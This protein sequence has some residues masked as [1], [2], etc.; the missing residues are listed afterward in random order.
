[1]YQLLHLRCRG[2][3]A[4][5]FP[6]RL[7]RRTLRPEAQRCRSLL[8]V[9]LAVVLSRRPWPLPVAALDTR[10][11]MGTGQ[12]H[13]CQIDPLWI[14]SKARAARMLSTARN[15]P[16]PPILLSTR[17]ATGTLISADRC[18]A[19]VPNEDPLY[20]TSRQYRSVKPRWKPSLRGVARR[21]R[22]QT[23]L[24]LPLLLRRASVRAPLHRL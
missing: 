16:T 7:G 1:M 15:A 24:L 12:R 13:R 6:A 5:R 21:R 9:D 14:N 17:L 18:R 22:S 10:L 23:P 4:T 8:E 19:A 11:R 3:P 20:L 2:D